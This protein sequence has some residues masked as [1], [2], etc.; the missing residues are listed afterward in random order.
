MTSKTIITYGTFDMFHIGHL[1]LLKRLK[2]MGNKLIVGVSTDKF[3]TSKGKKTIIPF[4]QRIQ[5]VESIRYVD[6]V[7]AE[8]SWDQKESDIQQ[9]NVDIFAIGEDWKGKFDFLESNCQVHYLPR[10]EGI[11][12]SD[13]KHQLYQISNLNPDDLSTIFNILQ[14]LKED[15]A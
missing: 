12:T 9:H 6:Q 11:S 10:T 8:E 14:N 7:I 2:Q 5:I 1:Q 3:N 15:F 4:D 13:I